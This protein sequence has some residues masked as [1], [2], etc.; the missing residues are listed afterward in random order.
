MCF[1]KVFSP[2]PFCRGGGTRGNV[3][4]CNTCIQ[5][6]PRLRVRVCLRACVCVWHHQSVGVCFR[7]FCVRLPCTWHSSRWLCRWHS[8]HICTALVYTPKPAEPPLRAPGHSLIRSKFNILNLL[9]S[10]SSVGMMYN[11]FIKA[12]SNLLRG[13]L[14]CLPG[15]IIPTLRKLHSC[16]SQSLSL[17]AASLEKGG[18]MFL[19]WNKGC[20]ISI[21]SF[22][23]S[24]L[25]LSIN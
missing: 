1:C 16:I 11:Q 25:T 8:R 6:Y 24:S 3:R 10:V 14:S 9:W 18:E 4:L 22:I 5:N 20:K 17:K 2:L 15:C 7:H 21:S 12:S 19:H 23:I 13:S